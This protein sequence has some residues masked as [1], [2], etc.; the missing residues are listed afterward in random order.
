MRYLSLDD[1]LFINCIMQ[2]KKIL[3]SSVDK[4]KKLYLH[5]KYFAMTKCTCA[6]NK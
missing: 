6:L 4:N 5:R 1:Y 2:L 3:T